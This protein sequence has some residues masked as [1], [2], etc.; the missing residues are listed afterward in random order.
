MIIQRNCVQCGARY[1]IE[2]LKV[3]SPGNK[4][5]SICRTRES[6]ISMRIPI[7]RRS[8]MFPDNLPSKKRKPTRSPSTVNFTSNVPV[9]TEVV[10]VFPFKSSSS[11]GTIYECRLYSNGATS[12]QCPGWTRRTDNQ[13]RRECKH[14]R[15]VDL[16]KGAMLAAL[17]G[18]DYDPATS[19]FPVSGPTSRN[20]S[21]PAH[22]PEAPKPLRRFDLDA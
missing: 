22:A 8:E 5:C 16:K 19:P 2:G 20:A 21:K 4:L 17:K 7:L 10:S 6:L 15:E 12:C 3:A 13:G 14:T 1:A 18:Q 11:P 9:G